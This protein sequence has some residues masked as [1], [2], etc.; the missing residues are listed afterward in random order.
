[1][2]SWKNFLKNILWI[3]LNSKYIIL[4]LLIYKK[5]S[6][7]QLLNKKIDKIIEK[8]EIKYECGSTRSPIESKKVNE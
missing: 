8:K 1:M 7:I 2:N 4:K 6:F 3:R 5:L